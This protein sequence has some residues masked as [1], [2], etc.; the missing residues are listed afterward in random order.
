MYRNFNSHPIL[1]GIQTQLGTSKK[2]WPAHYIVKT[3]KYILSQVQ[4]PS[5]I[6]D[7]IWHSYNYAIHT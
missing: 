3:G 6:Q 2:L 7:F 5:R 1:V 4:D